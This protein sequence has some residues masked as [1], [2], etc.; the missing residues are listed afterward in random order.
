MKRCPQCN[1]VETDE[2]LKFCRVD[3]TTLV[4]DASSISSEVGTAPFDAAGEASEVHTS[5]LPHHTKSNVNRATAP[6]TVLSGQ[7]VAS[8]TNELGPRTRS[9][10]MFGVVSL[11]GAAIVVATALGGYLYFSRQS[12]SAIDSIAV[13]PF[14]NQNRDPDTEYLSDG[15]TESIINSL[16][17]LPSLRVSPRS[18]VFQ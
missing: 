11:A 16:T 6:T 10:A 15:L 17:Q 14:V 1:R 8:T 13:L 5:I 4:V 3:G 7:P 18:S 12:K 2:A 9:K